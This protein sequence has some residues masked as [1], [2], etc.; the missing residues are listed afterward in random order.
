MFKTILH[1]NDGSE[2]ASKA[3]VLAVDLAKLSG[4]SLHMVCVEEISDFPET[5]GEVSDEKRIAGRFYRPVIR[6]AEQ[7]AEEKGVK[8]V[9][10][11]VAGHPVR[12]IIMLAVDL[13]ADL[14]VIGR[15]RPLNLLRA[16]PRHPRRPSGRPIALPG[17]RGEVTSS[18]CGLGNVAFTLRLIDFNR[19]VG[20]DGGDA[21]PD[22][23]I[24]PDRQ[25]VG[26]DQAG[27]DD[28]R[29]R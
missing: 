14:L 26:R 29:I 3:L 4:A 16:S 12:D 7:L 24:G 13:K 22:E 11:L 28:R 27:K 15:H 1:A 25:R 6:R 8:L 19:G 17:S 5:I 10:H 18:G 2:G 20:V 23:K 21:E 9:T